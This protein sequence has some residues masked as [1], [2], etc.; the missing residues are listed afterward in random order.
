MT[1]L[2]WNHIKTDRDDSVNLLQIISQQGTVL[3]IMFDL[4]EGSCVLEVRGAGLWLEGQR[5][6]MRNTRWG[7]LGEEKLTRN[8]L[9]SEHQSALEQEP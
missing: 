9:D 2:Q 6:W 1:E 5:V 7:N 4:N 8:S 3:D